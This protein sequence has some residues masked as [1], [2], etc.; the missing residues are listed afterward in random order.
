M[1]LLPELAEQVGTAQSRT[2]LGLSRVT[3]YR[4][5]RPKIASPAVRVPP[6]MLS[7][8]EQ[9]MVLDE[10]MA[11]ASLVAH[12]GDRDRSFRSIVTGCC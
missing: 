1:S 8:A 4:Q 7:E 3:V 6:L 5:R 11:R 12:F 10:L 9:T 2:G